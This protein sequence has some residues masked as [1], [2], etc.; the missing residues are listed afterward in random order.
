MV[1]RGHVQNGV[2]VL[3]EGV[4]LPEGEEVTVVSSV[5]AP[6]VKYPVSAEQRD[7]ILSLIGCL[8]TDNPPNDEEVEQIIEEARMKKYG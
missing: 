2:V 3:P 5:P 8:K 7:A 1:V 6:E 4:H